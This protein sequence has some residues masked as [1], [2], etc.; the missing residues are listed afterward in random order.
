MRH[1]L[2]HL[3]QF[4]TEFP[5]I[6]RCGKRTHTSVAGLRRRVGAACC[7][8]VVSPSHVC[9][10]IYR[11]F[12]PT[13]P[14]ISLRNNCANK[15]QLAQALG[16]LSCCVALFRR[17]NVYLGQVWLDLDM[18]KGSRGSAGHRWPSWLTPWDPHGRSGPSLAILRLAVPRSYAGPLVSTQGPPW[19]TLG[20]GSSGL[21]K[22]PLAARGCTFACPYGRHG[23]R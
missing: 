15:K 12:R 1:R 10:C 7:S 23:C 17:G 13:F 11:A 2:L 8:F 6:V 5:I 18:S 3:L 14:Y 21:L 22:A 16:S 19:A 4:A 9:I 20:A